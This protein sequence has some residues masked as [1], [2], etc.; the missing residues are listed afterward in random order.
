MQWQS[1]GAL[2]YGVKEDQWCTLHHTL[3]LYWL[4]GQTRETIPIN[5]LRPEFP[6]PKE[7]QY[8]HFILTLRCSV[9]ETEHTD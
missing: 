6:Y 9:R 1:S 3:H 5:I 8:A 2:Q 4:F 7:L